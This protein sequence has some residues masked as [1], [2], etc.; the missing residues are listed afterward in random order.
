MY[1]IPS[2]KSLQAAFGVTRGAD[3][4]VVLDRYRDRNPFSRP[5]LGMANRIL[6]GQGIVTEELNGAIV[7]YVDLADSYATTLMRVNGKLRIGSF[8]DYAESR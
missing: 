6:G 5:S 8:G 2:L 3:L 1:Q 7:S 4:R